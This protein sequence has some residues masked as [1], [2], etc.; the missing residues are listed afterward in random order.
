MNFNYRY[1]TRQIFFLT[2]SPASGE[3]TIWS[4]LIVSVSCL[5]RTLMAFT[6]ISPLYLLQLSSPQ[7][8]HYSDIHTITSDYVNGLSSIHCYKNF[9]DVGSGPLFYRTFHLCIWELAFLLS[10]YLCLLFVIRLRHKGL[11]FK[12]WFDGSSGKG[13]GLAKT[14]CFLQ[15]ISRFSEA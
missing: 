1:K 3:R 14:F 4:V 7:N 11:E 5:F 12:R 13:W 15:I 10:T 9:C 6:S 8:T 2:C